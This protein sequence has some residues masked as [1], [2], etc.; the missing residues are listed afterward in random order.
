MA[1]AVILIQSAAVHV[2]HPLDVSLSE[3][4]PTIILGLLIVAAAVALSI[5]RKVA[6]VLFLSA[7][8]LNIVLTLIHMSQT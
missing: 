8:G 6:R 4:L 5:L 2:E 1:L 7:L 3:K